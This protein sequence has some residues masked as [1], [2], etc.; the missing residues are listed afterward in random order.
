MTPYQ[1]DIWLKMTAKLL[2]N[3]SV[4][5][6]GVALFAAMGVRFMDHQIKFGVIAGVLLFWV[7]MRM[8]RY[9]AP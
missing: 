9:L 5:C 3:L 6:M 1:K 2:G 4:L 8:L 7:S